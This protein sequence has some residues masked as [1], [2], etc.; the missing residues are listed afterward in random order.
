M[1]DRP[2]DDGRGESLCPPSDATGQSVD[3]V[4]GWAHKTAGSGWVSFAV[5]HLSKCRHG[6]GRDRRQQDPD[7][8]YGRPQAHRWMWPD[9]RLTSQWSF[10]FPIEADWSGCICTAGPGVT[11][12][13]S[14]WQQKWSTDSKHGVTGDSYP[15]HNRPIVGRLLSLVSILG[16]QEIPFL[17]SRKKIETRDSRVSLTSLLSM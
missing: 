13:I 15:A 2:P 1:A 14:T 11:R 8:G 9:D 12:V 17:G 6:A 5:A 4:G 7:A 3:V 10:L 16:S